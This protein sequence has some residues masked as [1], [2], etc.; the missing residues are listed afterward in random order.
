MEVTISII[1]YNYGRYLKQAIDSALMQSFKDIAIEILVIDDGS[2][3]ESDDVIA[4]YTTLENFRAS[5]TENR[6]FAASL[7]RAVTEA[8][9]DYVFLLDA[10]DYFASNKVDK[11]LPFLL[12]GNLYICDTS[13]YVNEKGILMEGGAAGSTSTIA[14]NKKAVL[15]LLPVENELS[16]FA[17][18][19]LGYGKI[20]SQSLTFYRMHDKSMTDR[21][22]PGKWNFYLARITDNLSKRLVDIAGLNASGWNVSKKKIL[23]TAFEF[24]SQAYYNKLEA[25]LERAEYFNAFKNCFFMIYW[26]F[27]S[28]KY[29]SVFHLKMVVKTFMLRPSVAKR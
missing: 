13:S 23:F 24:K 26:L 5:K 28:K 21:N 10:D 8:K 20:L 19:K 12:Q 3:D 2:N 22:N 1:N 14:L 27:K 9:G 7:T 16:F 15:P 18:Y 17:L 4:H 25:S 6:G 29:I 11:M